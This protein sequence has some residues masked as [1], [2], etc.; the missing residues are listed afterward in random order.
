MQTVDLTATHVAGFEGSLPALVWGEASAVLPNIPQTY[1]EQSYVQE[2]LS[3]AGYADIEAWR[4]APAEARIASYAVAETLATDLSARMRGTTET[5][6]LRTIDILADSPYEPVIEDFLHDTK[7]IGSALAKGGRRMEREES[8]DQNMPFSDL[9]RYMLI[10]A[11]DSEHSPLEIL[12]YLRQR[13]G[14]PEVWLHGYPTV[15]EGRNPRNKWSH[16]QFFGRRAKLYVPVNGEIMLFEVQAYR[17]K[18][19][20]EVYKATRGSYDKVRMCG[21]FAVRGVE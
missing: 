8:H 4:Q 6:G 21:E 13:F 15:Y 18:E 17:R 2:M 9:H 14:V 5:I 12:D 3:L 19:Y 1:Y 20:E 16:P 7:T 11:D 10:I